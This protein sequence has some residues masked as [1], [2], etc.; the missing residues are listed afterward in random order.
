MQTNEQNAM[1]NLLLSVVSKKNNSNKTATTQKHAIIQEKTGSC[2]IHQQNLATQEVHLQ[3]KRILRR[4]PI[5]PNPLPTRQVLVFHIR[6][7]ALPLV[8]VL[9]DFLHALGGF[10]GRA[11]DG[12][13]DVADG[14]LESLFENL[15]DWVADDAEKTLV[16]WLVDEVGGEEE[17]GGVEFAYFVLV[18][19]TFGG[20]VG[21]FV[22]MECGCGVRSTGSNQFVGPVGIKDSN[23][24]RW[25]S[26]S[27]KQP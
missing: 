12:A 3:P 19:G 7:L 4:L 13:C 22:G 23:K 5:P 16:V 8:R 26:S 11:A 24:S 17:R 27:S 20:D 6:L 25:Y 14:G 21:H 9:G 15:S 2:S 18:E 1:H 10:A